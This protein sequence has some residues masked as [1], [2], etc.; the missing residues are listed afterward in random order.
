M[1]CFYKIYLLHEFLSC[2]GVTYLIGNFRTGA[3][4]NRELNFG[5]RAQNIG[6]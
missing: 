3:R 4:K 6:V 2:M 5:G 1:A